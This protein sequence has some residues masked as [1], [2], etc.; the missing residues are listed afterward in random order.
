[1]T[2]TETLPVGEKECVSDLSGIVLGRNWD[3]VSEDLH[4]NSNSG[5]YCQ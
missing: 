2:Q 4:L 1:M 5:I 3:G